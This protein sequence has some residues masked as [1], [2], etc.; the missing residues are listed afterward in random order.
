MSWE[1]S[2]SPS[3]S[4]SCYRSSGH[5]CLSPGVPGQELQQCQPFTKG[6]WELCKD[7]QTSPDITLMAWRSSVQQKAGSGMY[8]R[9][10]GSG[11]GGRGG[12]RWERWEGWQKEGNHLAFQPSV[13]WE[14]ASLSS[15][16]A[17]EGN[18]SPLLMCLKL[19]HNAHKISW[20]GGMKIQSAPRAQQQ[21][22][23]V[24]PLQLFLV[25]QGSGR[26]N[27]GCQKVPSVCDTAGQSPFLPPPLNAGVLS[28][29]ESM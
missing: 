22:Q 3:T 19:K 23:P 18:R 16:N 2:L 11:E 13:L 14:G 28:M 5:R 29:V 27:G 20:R 21:A 25:A 4:R 1:T 8:Y 7:S 24:L 15:Q 26:G 6:L 10:L 9:E 17:R 12:G